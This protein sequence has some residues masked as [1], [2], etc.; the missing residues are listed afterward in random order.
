MRVKRGQQ[1][2]DCPQLCQLCIDRTYQDIQLIQP[3]FEINDQNLI[4]TKQCLKPYV[5]QFIN[6]NPYSKIAKY[7]SAYVDIIIS[8]CDPRKYHKFC[9]EDYIDIHYFNQLAID[10]IDLN[11]T[12]QIQGQFCQTPPFQ[13]LAKTTFK[14]KI[15]N[16]QKIQILLNSVETLFFNF[17]DLVQIIQYDSIIINNLGFIF[18]LK[19]IGKFEFI[20][21]N[22]KVDITLNKFNIKDSYINSVESVLNTMI[23]GNLN[24]TNI[25]I[26]NT[27][28]QNSSFLNLHLYDF[29][30]QITIDTITISNS[31]INNS[32][33]F[34]FSK[35]QFN[36]LIKNLVINHCE[37]INSSFIYFTL[38][39]I[40]NTNLI[41]L[42][43]NI[44]DN[45][46]TNSSF[47]YCSSQIN[48][49]IYNFLF[50][51]N[52]VLKSIILGFNYNL[53]LNNINIIE[54]IF[55]DSQ[56]LQTIQ[57]LYEYQIT[58]KLQYLEAKLNLFQNS[59]LFLLFS[60]YQMSGFIVEIQDIILDQ[61]SKSSNSNSSNYLFNINCYK[62]IIKNA[63]IINSD[64]MHIFYL[65]ENYKII[66]Q[67][68][69]Y[70]QSKLKSKV[71]LSLDCVN[72][73]KPINQLLQIQGFIDIFIQDVRVVNQVSYDETLIQISSSKQYINEINR[74]III[75]RLEFFGNLLLSSIQIIRLSL[76]TISSDQNLYVSLEDIKFKR[77][78]MHI[79]QEDSL[80]YSAGLIYI[81]S[82]QSEVKIKG[83][84]CYENAYTNSSNSFIII[85]SDSVELNNIEV[86]YHNILPLNLWQEYYNIST[87]IEFN[88]DKV[89]YFISQVFQIKIIG[90][91]FQISASHIHCIN[92]KFNSIFALKS[93]I[94]DIITFGQGIVQLIYVTIN[95][96][97][98]DLISK[99]KKTGCINI[100]SQT[101]LLNLS[102]INVVFIKVQN[103]ITSSI[104]TIY[105]SLIS[106]QILL[107]N[108]IIEDCFSL[109]NQIINAQFQQQIAHLNC[110][111]FKNIQ[112]IQNLDAMINFFQQVKNLTSNEVLA[113]TDIN[114]AIIL[115]ENC[116]SHINGLIFEGIF[117]GPLLLFINNPKLIFYNC[118]IN[119]IQTIYSLNLIS[120]NQN[121]QEKQ[122][123]SFS[124]ISI[125]RVSIFE[126]NLDQIIQEQNENYFII[127]CILN[128]QGESRTE[129]HNYSKENIIKLQQ[130]QPYQLNSILH[131]E[132]QSNL[133]EF[134]FNFIQLQS[135]NCSTCSDGIAFFE[136]SKF[137]KLTVEQ[138]NCN[139]NII[140]NFGCL[141]FESKLNI[142][143]RIIIK[144]S[145]FINNL[146]R[147]G[148]A[149]RVQKLPLVIEQV[150][151][152]SNFANEKGGG[153]YVE[154][155]S[156][157]YLIKNTIIM[158]NKA[159]AGGGIYLSGDNNLNK[160]NIINTIL[161]YNVGEV[162]GN[163]IVEQPTHLALQINDKEQP[164]VKLIQN[165]TELNLLNLQAYKTIEQNILRITKNLM[166]PSNQEIQNYT[167]FYLKGK[168]YITQ[169]KQMYLYF[170][171]S[172]NENLLDFRDSSC[173][174]I[175][176]VVSNTSNK[177]INLNGN[178]ILLINQQKNSFDIGRLSFSLDPYNQMKSYLQIQLSCNSGLSNKTLKYII[179]SNSYKCQL[180]EFYVD[181]GCQICKS[182]QGFYS[183]IYDS[184]KCSI[185][186]KQKFKNITS[187]MIQLL[188]GNW[189]PHYLSDYSEQCF[190]NL[191]FCIGGWGVGNEL[192]KI[193]HIGGLCEECDIDNIIGNGQYFKNQWGLSCQQCFGIDN[194][195]FSFILALFQ[196]LISIT[197]SLRSIHKSNRLFASLKIGQKFSNIIFR[198]NQD[199]ESILLKMWLNYLWIF[200]VIFTFNI[201]FQFQFT[202]IDTTS[203]SF[204][205]MA[206]NLDCYLSNQG[207]HLIYM[208]IFIILQLIL[209]Q[210]SIVIVASIIYTK[211]KK[212]KIDYSILSTTLLYLFIFNYGGL[213]KMLCSIVSNRKI[214]NMN[215]IQGDVSLYFG[216]QNH[217]FWIIYLI[218]PGLFLFGCLIPF[219]LLLLMHIK[220]HQFDL[221]KFRKHIAIFGNLLKL[222]Q[223]L[224]LYQLLLIFETNILLKASL[225][226]FSL[227]VYQILAGNTKPYNLSKFNILDLR[228]GQICSLSIFLA[229]MKYVSEEINNQFLSVTLSIILIIL[230]LQLSIPFIKDILQ[231]YY[232]KFKSP[233][234]TFLL[235]L[236]N[237]IKQN[238]MFSIYLNHLL[239][240]WKLKENRVKFI[241]S[242]IR[243][244]LLH[245]LRVQPES[246]RISQSQ[247]NLIQNKT[248][249]QS[250]FRCLIQLNQN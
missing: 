244:N 78:F 245:Q 149:I 45:I 197:L 94:F 175:D 86:N 228:T 104:L 127:G 165:N 154:L 230:C 101:S 37:L 16:L 61:N 171:N 132:S 100:N 151:I 186:D 25:S 179:N 62:I 214:S 99:S 159:Q 117:I 91:S 224:Q 217:I 184:I 233:C 74:K 63:K 212:L 111:T 106:N 66:I 139:Y 64:S 201:N 40:N 59:N 56:F 207:I 41:F 248:F 200:S 34:K 60:I 103:R 203:N 24:F 12:F 206:Y 209:I 77:N 30:G 172:Y 109:L 83:L 10:S 28:I 222:L 160:E 185:F 115:L 188:K 113:I 50:I 158:Y 144:N 176:K 213:I 161:I 193:G 218:V 226:G 49:S 43:L 126:K 36:I 35:N 181:D 247:F 232:Q 11:S 38:N 98:T 166:I 42:N 153:L 152:I 189:R 156:S 120:I 46:F 71:Q 231:V 1:C 164:S 73:D 32:Q 68:V 210:L 145:N 194:G 174:V 136:I 182:N 168:Q 234:I 114:N 235:C 137:G 205:F 112:I 141:N 55:I 225:V 58:C 13:I 84:Y 23:F 75:N 102:I 140:Q 157:N 135:N 2:S 82:T 237:Q 246:R 92:S 211:F 138:L 142:K 148:V 9:Y 204:Y 20:N 150:K 162:Y 239:Q 97:H 169:I 3:L 202:L 87:D 170:K 190:K 123:V 26:I 107:D 128:K 240:Q 143:S 72:Q 118:Q 53:L 121:N 89:N 17:Q 187:N 196:A 238:S 122:V 215:Y 39:Q 163:N 198:L 243:S 18:N 119:N 250:T 14:S 21:N 88:Q 5:D 223:K 146:G 195:I 227:L 6:F 52:T 177:K 133:N 130:S 155:N 249:Q 57:Q 90:G 95:Q 48:L 4:Y 216:T 80:L 67:N 51:N 15:F 134:N 124:Q 33:M 22:K 241:Y 47:L 76:I 173:I 220:R 70:K 54:N 31:I 19:S 79:Y 219:A 167:L 192:C 93:Q 85:T 105:P 81:I 131:I 191:E 199:H 116:I 8:I 147:E 7:Y 180:G 65:F 125:Q 27:Q 242:K 178:Q 69:L 108:V 110:I 221:I 229:T 96:S 129:Q 208:R 44:S 236:I 183:V 29:V